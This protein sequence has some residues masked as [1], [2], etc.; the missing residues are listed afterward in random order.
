MFYFKEVIESMAYQD[1]VINAYRESL[2]G[3]GISEEVVNSALAAFKTG[4]FAG[5]FHE[6]DLELQREMISKI[7]NASKIN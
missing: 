2:K 1:E 7:L 5:T 6:G 4:Y 3:Y